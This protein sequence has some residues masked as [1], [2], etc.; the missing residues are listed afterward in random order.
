MAV[1]A[2]VNRLI[3]ARQIKW[4]EFMAWVNVHG[5]SRWVYRGL[6]DT[7]FQLLTGVGR[8]D[9]Y[10]PVNERTVLE[11]F[12]RRA[13]EF[14]DTRRSLPWDLLALAQHH[15][16]PTRLLDWTTNPLVAAYFAVSAEP[17]SIEVDDLNPA[18]DGHKMTVRRVLADVPARVVAWQV[19]AQNVVDPAV[20][21]DP[22]VLSAIK[23]LM[24]RVLTTRISTQGGLFSV[25]PVPDAP[26]TDPLEKPSDIF[27]IPGEMRAYFQQKLFFLGVDDQR[28]M[29]GLDGLCRRL[30]WQYSTDVGLG[31]VR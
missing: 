1:S 18:W 9:G 28:I 27:D 25:H 17:A 31:A 8:S 26:W 15:G 11:I 22:F 12:E 6:G 14:I 16:L 3:R 5:D 10:S 29:G 7:S 24:P 4:S 21:D 13:S 19:E 2:R 23:Y 30:A 20:D